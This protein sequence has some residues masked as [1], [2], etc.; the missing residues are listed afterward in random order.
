[1]LD[2]AEN[3]QLNALVKA[4][5]FHE[6][7]HNNTTKIY[8]KTPPPAASNQKEEKLAIGFHNSYAE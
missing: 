3:Q 7:S 8:L 5:N 2:S 6:A 1:L 4:L